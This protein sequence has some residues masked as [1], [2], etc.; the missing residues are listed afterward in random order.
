[1]K[2]LFLIF[3]IAFLGSC[4]KKTTPTSNPVTASGIITTIAGNGSGG[5]SGDGGP[6]TAAE[7][8]IGFGGIAVDGTGNVFI[9]EELNERIRKAT[10]TGI[11]STIAGNGAGASS[12]VGSYSGDGGPAISAGLGDPSDVAV[13]GSGNVYICDTRNNRIRKVTAAG[14]ISTIATGLNVPYGVAVD[15]NNNV[16]IADQN[17]NLVKKVNT[18]G[19]ISIVAGNGTQGYDGDGGIATAAELTYPTGIA[20]DGSGNIYIADGGNNR[21]RKVTTSG[22]ITTVAGNGFGAIVGTGSA[23]GGY[24]GDGGAAT[25]AELNYPVSVAVDASGNIYIADQNNNRIR[26]VNTLGIISTFAGNGTQAFAN[27]IGDGGAATAAEV[28]VPGGVA[29]DGSGNVYILDGSN[30]IRKVSK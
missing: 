19:I 8:N 16:Y 1:M 14:I 15:G 23:S 24:S 5:Y 11:I 27:L 2:N 4:T 21:I 3:I 20:V 13:D 25:A 12:G 10:I 17:N 26:K 28:N 18:S 29:V 7:M 6:A 9:A 30:R 22:I